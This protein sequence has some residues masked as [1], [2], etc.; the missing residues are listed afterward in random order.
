M[1]LRPKDIKTVFYF[2]SAR[3]FVIAFACIKNDIS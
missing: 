1:Q 3:E 2:I